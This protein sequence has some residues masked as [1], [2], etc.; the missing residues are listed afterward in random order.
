MPVSFEVG[1]AA[2]LALMAGL[3]VF[4]LRFAMQQGRRGRGPG[5]ESGGPDEAG[6]LDQS[7]P[8]TLV[9]DPDEGG[10]G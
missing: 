7:A 2:F 6:R 5:P 4:V 9:D 1:F 10:D 8:S 3:V